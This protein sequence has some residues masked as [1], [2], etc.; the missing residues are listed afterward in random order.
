MASDLSVPRSPGSTFTSNEEMVDGESNSLHLELAPFGL[1]YI[2]NYK[3]NG[4][5]PI[6]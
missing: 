1:E 2:Y 6:H 3:L 4:H 5:Y